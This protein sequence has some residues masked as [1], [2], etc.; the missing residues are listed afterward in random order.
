M[1]L[2]YCKLCGDMI[3][4]FRT[5][6]KPRACNCGEYVV[7][8]TDPDA[9]ILRVH[10]HNGDRKHGTIIGI[11]NCLLNHDPAPTI[12]EIKNMAKGIHFDPHSKFG[13]TGSM[14]VRLHPGE[15]LD[16]SWADKVP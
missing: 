16:T 9:G 4:P 8:W 15:S 10:S 12:S 14:V 11:H 2:L 5:A 6:N 13:L 1:K 7:W 3:A